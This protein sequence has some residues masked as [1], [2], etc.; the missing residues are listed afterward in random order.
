[1]HLTLSTLLVLL[2]AAIAMAVAP[3]FHDVII[4]FP[5]DAP[6]HL[7]EDAKKKVKDTKG[8]KITHEYSM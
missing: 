4:S 5:K 2:F 1:M 6:S 3:T 7:L 8:A